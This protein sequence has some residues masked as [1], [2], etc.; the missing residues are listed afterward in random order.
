MRIALITPEYPGCG[1]SFGIGR[2]VAD[3]AAELVLHGHAVRV[4]VAADHG[5]Y[6]CSVGPPPQRRAPA[7]PHL[8]LRPLA[9]RSWLQRELQAFA[10]EI[11]D[12]PNWGGL[13]T[14]LTGPWATVVRLSTSSGDSAFRR[15][16]LLRWLSLAWERIAVRRA[17]GVIADSHAMAAVGERLY[18]RRCDA[19]HLHAYRGTI[20][21]LSPRREAVLFVGRLELRKGID[22]LLE[23][24]PAVHRALPGCELHIVGRDLTNW[25]TRIP[26]N[27]GITYHGQ[28]GDAELQHLRASCRVQ[29]VPSR[30][31]SFGLVVLEAWAAGM[32]VVA[33]SVGGLPEVVGDAGELV[34][35]EDSSALAAALITS[36]NEK[37]A[38]KM[39]A[40]G[41]QRLRSQFSAQAWVE[42]AVRVYQDFIFS[43]D[44]D[45][46]GPFDR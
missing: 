20:E 37:H 12:A 39:S 29:V 11:V 46:L 7:C 32:S 13:S 5:C 26:T 22:V 18:G 19:V 17:T 25:G 1:P 40:A 2:Y 24:W 30:F 3:L 27:C 36:I 23:A 4:L 33:T 38:M 44:L 42:S 14:T 31:E 9:C 45:A 15:T 16:A 10:P 21:P 28:L 6:A 43:C 41:Q 35:G 34:P 8:L